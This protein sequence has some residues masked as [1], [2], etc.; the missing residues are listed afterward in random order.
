MRC[1]RMQVEMAR[2]LKHQQ[3]TLRFSKQALLLQW[4]RA[5]RTSTYNGSNDSPRLIRVPLHEQHSWCLVDQS[6]Q[7]VVERFLGG[8]R[9]QVC[10]KQ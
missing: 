1:E 5:S 8:Q 3:A 6:L 2:W 9:Q 4:R 7:L 10:G